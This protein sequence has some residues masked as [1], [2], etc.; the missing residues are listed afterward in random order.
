MHKIV[1][2]VSGKIFSIAA[3]IAAVNTK[4]TTRPVGNVLVPGFAKNSGEL[5][6][7]NLVCRREKNEGSVEELV[8]RSDDEGGGAEEWVGKEEGFVSIFSRLF[9]FRSQGFCISRVLG[10]GCS[11]SSSANN[12][13][14]S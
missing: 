10:G 12:K 4:S 14:P 3:E 5:E 6:R 11:S 7:K 13:D 9:F 1:G 8:D 2:R